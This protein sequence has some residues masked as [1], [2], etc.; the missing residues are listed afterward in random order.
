MEMTGK[1]PGTSTTVSIPVGRLNCG[2]RVQVLGRG[3]SWLNIASTHG[4]RYVPMTT[5]WQRKDRFVAVDLPLTT[6]RPKTGKVL[7]QIIY[8]VNPVYT[9]E[10]LKAGIHGDVYVKLAIEADGAV[11][12][13]KVLV[14]LGYG[15]DEN[16]IK[17][18]QSWAFEPALQDGVPMKFTGA[19]EVSFL[20]ADK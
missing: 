5:I 6:D 2:D 7:P 13:V 9:Q 10:A 11:H 4:E 19:V 16:A 20:P 15:L 1:K 12:D 14:G 3:G 18:V 17:A 8:S